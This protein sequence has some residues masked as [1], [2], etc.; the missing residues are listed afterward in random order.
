LPIGESTPDV[1]Y[2]E[3]QSQLLQWAGPHTVVNYAI[4]GKKLL[5]SLLDVDETAPT[6]LTGVLDAPGL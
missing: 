3:S 6:S 5:A 2:L 4:Q 1:S